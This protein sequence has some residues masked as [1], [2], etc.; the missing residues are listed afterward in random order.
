ITESS[1]IA[2]T[3]TFNGMDLLA[4]D[5]GGAR[6]FGFQ[7]GIDGSPTSTLQVKGA[8][9]GSLSGTVYADYGILPNDADIDTISEAFGGQIYRTEFTATHI[10]TEDTEKISFLVGFLVDVDSEIVAA[11]GWYKQ[12]SSTTEEYTFS[13]LIAGF[14]YDENTQ[15]ATGSTGDPDDGDT[16]LK[17]NY[18]NGFFVGDAEVEIGTL[19]FIGT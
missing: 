8:D 19:R 12:A 9:T 5:R 6:N 13:G 3:T 16:N 17:I 2:A 14:A 11:V 10:K 1:R 18:M 4:A 7:I 15:R